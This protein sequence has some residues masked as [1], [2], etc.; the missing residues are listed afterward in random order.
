MV[1]A[2][3]EAIVGLQWDEGEMDC[4]AVCSLALS[5]MGMDEA[6]IDLSAC[7]LTGLVGDLW[8]RVK[9]GYARG[10][11]VLSSGEEGRLHTS[12]VYG[13]DARR[14]V[15]SARVIGGYTCRLSTIK[16]II[17]VYRYVPR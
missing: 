6:S 12:A 16:N 1:D 8:V 2:D 11:V 10:D 9:N 14:V 3:L 7:A 4:I 17:G 15:S 5:M 13:N